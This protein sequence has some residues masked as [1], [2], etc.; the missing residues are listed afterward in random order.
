MITEG[1]E[2]TPIPQLPWHQRVWAWL[3]Y[4]RPEGFSG[5]LWLVGGLSCLGLTVQ[6]VLGHHL[7]WPVQI[8]VLCALATWM[9][10]DAL[11]GHLK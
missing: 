3:R 10:T 8:V 11:G 1:D 7:S 9:I 4:M 6:V 5:W 2:T